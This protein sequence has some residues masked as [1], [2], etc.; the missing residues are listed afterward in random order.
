M[1]LFKIPQNIPRKK[2][3]PLQS[4]AFQ[5]RTPKQTRNQGHEVLIILYIY[6]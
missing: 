6:I 4:S 1:Y 5:T 2:G 3:N